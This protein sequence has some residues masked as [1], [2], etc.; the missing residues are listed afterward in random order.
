MDEK[1]LLN[2]LKTMLKQTLCE[3]DWQGKANQVCSLCKL[4]R[5]ITHLIVRD[6]AF[7]GTKKANHKHRFV[8][9]SRHQQ[10]CKDCGKKERV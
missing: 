7:A 8:K 1:D 9:T 5:D 10:I 2:H 4:R 6:G 3:H